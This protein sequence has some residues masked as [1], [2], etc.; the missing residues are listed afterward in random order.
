MFGKAQPEIRSNSRTNSLALSFSIEL[1]L[2]RPFSSFFVLFSSF[3][4][5]PFSSFFLPFSSF[6]SS[7]FFLF[8]PFFLPFSFL[9]SLSFFFIPRH[10]IFFRLF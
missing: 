3:F 8:L 6:F 4:P 1:F 2:F 9:F 10:S 7:F 5:F